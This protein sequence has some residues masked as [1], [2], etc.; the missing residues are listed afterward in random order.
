MARK[1][2]WWIF[3]KLFKNFGRVEPYEIY[4]SGQPGLIR[5][6]V[7]HRLFHFGAV[8]NLAHSPLHDD[9]DQ[10]EFKFFDSKGVK[11]HSY[12]WGAGGP[13]DW[14]EVGEVVDL[15]VEYQGLL[16]NSSIPVWIH[17]EGG[18]DRTGGVISMFRRKSGYGWWIILKDFE[19]H[20]VPCEPWLA[21][22]FN[23]PKV[24]FI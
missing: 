17:C 8:I 2:F 13:L 3:K 6:W 18:K 5:L 20:R 15:L 7:L 1:I 22:L 21:Y 19:R 16:N 12:V 10:K 24:E 23:R 4:R 11:Y 14:K 9:Q